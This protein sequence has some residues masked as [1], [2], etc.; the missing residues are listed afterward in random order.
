MIRINKLVKKFG[1]LEV[2]R[3][4][5]LELKKGKVITIIGPSGS[6]KST[7]LRCVNHLVQPTEGEIY[8]DDILIN[9][10]SLHG[11]KFQRHINKIRTRMGMVFQSFN[12]FPHM[13]VLENV[14]E[15]PIQVLKQNKNQAVEKA[16]FLL[17]KVG[18]YDKINE[19]PINL[20][21]G[22]SQ[23]VAIARALAMNPEVLLLDEITSALD[24]ELI[25]EVLDVILQL[26]KE[27]MT[28]LIVTHEMRFASKVS[29]EVI[30]LDHGVIVER[31]KPKKIFNSP[32]SKRTRDFLSEI[33]DSSYF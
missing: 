1:D 19:K 13:S 26:S 21:G 31:G 33:I 14:I 11:R 30:V 18:L 5:S 24:P 22:Q 2:L 7:I 15:A 16:E 20:S 23:R 28:M 12:L 29:D 9:D 8:I 3:G 10:L 25:K 32:D 27:G 6:G 4:V 17:K